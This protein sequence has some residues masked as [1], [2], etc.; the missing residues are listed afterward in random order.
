MSDGRRATDGAEDEMPIEI[1]VEAA[2]RLLDQGA[3]L[4]EA[5]PRDEFEEEHLPGAISIP[6]KTLD[7]SATARLDPARPT[8]VYCWDAQ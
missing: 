8:I 2:R 6:L 7:R 4:I 5:L 1:D 3:Q